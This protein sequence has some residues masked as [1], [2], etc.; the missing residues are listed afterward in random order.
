VDE[1]PVK[2]D[3]LIRP[4]G[5]VEHLDRPAPADVGGSYEPLVRLRLRG[6]AAL[7]GERRGRARYP[8]RPLRGRLVDRVE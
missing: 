5:Q 7:R 2:H 1:W 8:E 6:E 3:A 4:S